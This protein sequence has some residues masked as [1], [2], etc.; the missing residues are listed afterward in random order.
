MI[1]QVNL[2]SIMVELGINQPTSKKAVS[3][4]LLPDTLKRRS[5][6][7][8]KA[9]SLQH[10]HW[11]PLC[12]LWISILGS[13]AELLVMV[14]SNQPSLMLLLLGITLERKDCLSLSV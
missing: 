5:T 14:L 4:G 8:K 12:P 6:H 9:F 3:E 10:N 1:E 11:P 13:E 7:T 2:Q